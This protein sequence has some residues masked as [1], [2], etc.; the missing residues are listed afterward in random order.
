MHVANKYGSLQ[1]LLLL[2]FCLVRAFILL[3]RLLSCWVASRFD[4]RPLH[5]CSRLTE[6]LCQRQNLLLLIFLVS[7]VEEIRQ[8]L[9]YIT[10][11][12]SFV[13]LNVGLRYLDL[14]EP[15]LFN[16]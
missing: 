11:I 14:F 15:G 8:H 10:S 3:L 16:A 5:F 12:G 13:Q 4:H 7:L 6:Q 9:T 1:L 2:L